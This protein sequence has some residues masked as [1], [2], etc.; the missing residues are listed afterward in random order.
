[1]LDEIGAFGERRQDLRVAKLTMH[2]VASLRS[3]AGGPVRLEEMLLKSIDDR[4]LE[5]EDTADE[6]ARFDAAARLR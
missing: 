1:M 3:S 5:P 4:P 6:V 2:L